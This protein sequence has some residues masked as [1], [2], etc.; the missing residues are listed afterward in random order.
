M[1]RRLV[2]TAAEMDRMTASERAS[3]VG[4]ATIRDLGELPEQ[5]RSEVI[6]RALVHEE[7]LR[8]EQAG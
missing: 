5:F 2:V 8:N 3:V 1:E 4:S 7:R 6:A